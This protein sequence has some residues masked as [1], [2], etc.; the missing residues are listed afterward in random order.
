MRYHARVTGKVQ[1]DPDERLVLD[2]VRLTGEDFSGRRLQQISV[3]GSQ[4]IGCRFDNVSCESASLGAGQQMSYFTECVFDGA[5]LRFFAGGS[6]RFERCSF[7]D[8]DL[9]D[10]VCFAVELVDCTL[11]GR[12][13]QAVFN[14][15]VPEKRQRHLRRRVNEFRG[16]DFSGMDMTDTAFRTGIDL[17]LQ[18]L[19]TGPDYLYLSDAPAA[20]GHARDEVEAWQDSRLREAGAVLIRVLELQLENGQQQLLLRKDELSRGPAGKAVL[21]L[22]SSRG[23]DRN[24]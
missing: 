3:A 5:R 19:P 22:L 1:I 8:T 7:R 18:R 14:G 4:M 6:A 10:W 9:R 15:T 20:V 11:T 12:L 17:S 13:R 2:D 24:P 16:N 21:A 23:D